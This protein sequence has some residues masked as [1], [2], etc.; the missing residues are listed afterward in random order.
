MDEAAPIAIPGAQIAAGRTPMTLSTASK[1]PA[2]VVATRTNATSR[3]VSRPI[4][5]RVKSQDPLVENG[6][7]GP[8]AVAGGDGAMNATCM[9]ACANR[10]P[11]NTRRTS[12]SR[13][14]AY[15]LTLTA[16]AVES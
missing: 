6:H 13:A 5:S 4:P 3:V 16:G 11:A 15:E 10:K 12:M 1:K 7:S 8:P 9:S 2:I 14:S